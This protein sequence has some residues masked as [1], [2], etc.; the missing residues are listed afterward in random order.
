MGCYQEGVAKSD[1]NGKPVQA[2]LYEY[3]TQVCVEPDLK[4]C[5]TKDGYVPV[6]MLFCLKEDNKK[7]INSHRWFFNAFAPILQPTV[8]MLLDVGTKPTSHSIY[9]LWKAFD[10][11]PDLGGACGEVCRDLFMKTTASNLID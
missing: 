11:D 2:H 10:M 9:H 7:K 6:Q 1:V 3:T 8:C 5:G 4:V